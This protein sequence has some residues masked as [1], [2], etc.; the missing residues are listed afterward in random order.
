MPKLGMPMRIGLRAALLFVT[1]SLLMLTCKPSWAAQRPQPCAEARL[2]TPVADL[3]KAKFSDWR[4]KQISDLEADDQQL[5]T[6]AHNEECP[7]IAIG[8]F[9]GADRLAYAVLLV[10]KFQPTGGYRLVVFSK[11]P[12]KDTYGWKLL[13]RADGQSYSGLVISKVGPGKYSDFEGTKSIRI[14]LDAIYLEWIEKGADLYY[15]SAGR[16]RR[17][18]V[19]D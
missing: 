11:P 9:E 1:V 10:P 12:S 15:W 17:L 5:W 2:P 3:L 16:Y 18:R 7:G 6:Q 19:S 8:Y 13:D 14:R 4:P